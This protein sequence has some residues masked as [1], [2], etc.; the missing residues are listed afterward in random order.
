[1]TILRD[2]K[3]FWTH[4]KEEVRVGGA[5]VG[6]VEKIFREGLF[7]NRI[8]NNWNYNCFIHN[9]MTSSDAI[10]DVPNCEKCL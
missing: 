3:M 6:E 8:Y 2:K 9:H 4:E 7:S 10:R 1:M 5:F